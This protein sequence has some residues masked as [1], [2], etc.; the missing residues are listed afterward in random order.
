[1]IFR[2]F[3]GR[4]LEGILPNLICEM[5]TPLMLKAEDYTHTHKKKPL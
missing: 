3:K 2:L 4:E 1:M 5:S